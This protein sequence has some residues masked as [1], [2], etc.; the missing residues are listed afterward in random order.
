MKKGQCMSMAIK[1]SL[2]CIWQVDYLKTKLTAKSLSQIRDINKIPAKPAF[3][4]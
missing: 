4:N 3:Q 1:F 2:F